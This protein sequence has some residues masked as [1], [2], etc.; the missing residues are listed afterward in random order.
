MLF[1]QS[2]AMSKLKM[3]YSSQWFENIQMY[4][5]IFASHCRQ[6]MGLCI[7]LSDYTS[8]T[9]A[10][11]TFSLLPVDSMHFSVHC[12]ICCWPRIRGLAV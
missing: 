5:C 3:S 12:G 10:N 6:L 11:M 2:K 9:V 1:F 4:L 8:T 7:T